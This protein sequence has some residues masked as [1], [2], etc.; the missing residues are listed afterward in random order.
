MTQKTDLTLF[1]K[2]LTLVPPLFGAMTFAAGLILLFSGS[3]PSSLERIRWVQAVIPLPFFE[4][5]HF[6]GSLAGLFLLILARGIYRRL[7]AAY[8]VAVTL[9]AAGVVL[10]LVRGLH[11]EDALVLMVFLGAMV[12]SRPH[13][14]RKASLLHEPFSAGWLATVGT[15]VAASLGLG[16]WSYRNVVYSDQLWWRFGFDQDASRFL[17]AGVGATILFLGIALAN[18]LRPLRPSALAP[19]DADIRRV[20]PLVLAS[21]RCESHRALL[22]DKS[23][24]FSPSG[25]TFLMYRA[26]SGSFVALGDPIG[27]EEEWKDLLHHFRK[28]ADLYNANPVFTGILSDHLPL[29]LDLNLTVVKAGERARVD[30]SEFTMEGSAKSELRHVVRNLQNKGV[31]FEIVDAAAAAA[32]LPEFKAVSDAWL[33]KK[34]TKEKGFSLGFF[35]EP[36]LRMCPHAVVRKE[37]KIVAFANLWLGAE[38]EEFSPD[39]MRYHPQTAPSGVMEFLMTQLILWGKTEG[40]RWFVL[41]MAPLSGLENHEFSPLWSRVGAYIFEHSQRFYNFQGLREY[42]EKFGPVWTPSY[43]ACAGTVRIPRALKDI[44]ILNSGGLKGIFFK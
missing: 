1:R 34:R 40:Y 27:P 21:P 7:D 13:F 10:S 25:K 33:I 23:F 37:G 15:M 35:S 12:F 18:L 5:S 31:S 9:L 2:L 4:L 22:G 36:Y 38:H 14:Y 39:L 30:L 16:L 17:R 11:Y 41:G 26:M 6:L 28:Q 8:Y 32:L 29:Y 42:K 43:L 20:L 24:F 19:S 3:V 44:S